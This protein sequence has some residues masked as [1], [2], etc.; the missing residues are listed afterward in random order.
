MSE[1]SDS[2]PDSIPADIAD[3]FRQKAGSSAV[4]PRLPKLSFSRTHSHELA[5]LMGTL[6]AGCDPENEE[7][8]PSPNHYITLAVALVGAVKDIHT[9]MLEEAV[10]SGTRGE[11]IAALAQ[12][13]SAACMAEF[14]VHSMA[15]YYRT[16]MPD[17][18][19]SRRELISDQMLD[20]LGVSRS[21][22]ERWFHSAGKGSLPS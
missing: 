9:R 16:T 2:I 14:A 17:P 3:L 1:A 21:D 4:F 6:I 22:F 15:K 18:A 8:R 11:V 7:S 13:Y 5:I 10:D 19:S 20:A 12:L